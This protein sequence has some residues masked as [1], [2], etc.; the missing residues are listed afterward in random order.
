V[1]RASGLAMTHCHRDFTVCSCSLLPVLLP[2]GS[3]AP[4]NSMCSTT[5]DVSGEPAMRNAL[6][7]ARRRIAC[8]T[9]CGTECSHA[10]RPGRLP[11]VSTITAYSPFPTGTATTR[12]S[13]TANSRFRHPTH[14]RTGPSVCLCVKAEGS[15]WITAKSSVTQPVVRT[16]RGV[17]DVRVSVCPAISE[18]PSRN[19]MP[20]LVHRTDTAVP[21][22][23]ASYSAG[24]SSGAS[25]SRRRQR[26]GAGR[27][28][29]RC[30]S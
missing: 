8:C 18:I 30:T 5:A 28:A 25:S 16:T 14:V 13:S 6:V 7:K 15:R 12:S 1:G 4:R 24:H 10:P 22:T 29:R 19:S 26:A 2:G 9:H 27:G 11:P 3:G 23:D 17:R 20:P 21:S